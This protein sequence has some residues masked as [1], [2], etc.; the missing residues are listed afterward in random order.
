MAQVLKSR[1]HNKKTT[2]RAETRQDEATYCKYDE[3]KGKNFA[4]E[5]VEN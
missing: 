1:C 4:S 5:V 3:T 2:V